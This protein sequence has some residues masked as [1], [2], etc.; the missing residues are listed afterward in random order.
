MYRYTV[1]EGYSVSF[2]DKMVRAKNKSLGLFIFGIFSALVRFL[3]PRTLFLVDLILNEFP[4]YCQSKSRG[5]N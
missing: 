5:Q 1:T 4:C 3:S 2:A